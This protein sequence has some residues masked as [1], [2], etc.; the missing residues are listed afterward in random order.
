[1][2]EPQ[3][4]PAAEVTA[5]DFGYR[6]ELKRVLGVTDL[7]ILGLCMAVPISVVII[8]GFVIGAAQGAIAT[9]YLLAGIGMLLTGNSYARLSESF[10][11][12][13]GGY[14]F[15]SRG[16]SRLAGF[17]IGWAMAGMYLVLLPLL[18]IFGA[19]AL[20]ALWPA[21]PV[22]L[23]LAAFIALN[24]W[25]NYR[26]LEMTRNILR[27]ILG[28]GLAIYVWTVIA[29]L[30]AVMHGTG[31]AAF[32][33]APFSAAGQFDLLAVMAG[34]AIAVFNFGGPEM[35]TTLGEETKGGTRTLGR[36]V[37]LSFGLLGAF[38]L[39]LVWAAALAWPDYTT[40]GDAETAFYAI[41]E[42]VGGNS[43]KSAL[44]VAIVVTM[45]GS[46]ISAQACSARLLYAMGRDRM[47]P[48]WLARVHPKYQ[49]PYA[50]VLVTAVVSTLLCLAFPDQA[51]VMTSIVNFSLLLCWSFVNVT[52]IRFLL[53][54][55][56]S[57]R[58]FRDL[59]CPLLGLAVTGYAFVSLDD[60]ALA[61]GLAWLGLGVL[62]AFYLRYVRKVDWSF[63]ADAGL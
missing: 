46:C 42:R 26:G 49:S 59:A 5:A 25:A 52:A 35:L 12:A 11:L 16:L 2:T 50:G 44:V 47:L 37:L 17:L 22:Q 24:T 60:A 4:A 51:E 40:L 61:A 27:Y 15:V 53:L 48:R 58:W 9:V 62:F 34:V 41:A 13:G 28:A 39:L 38:F 32:T 7:V 8:Y 18:Y 33:A 57:G 19:H 14:A 31:G 1:M 54:R 3:T 21:V 23:W 63:A 56:Q 45:L 30:V 10:P 20:R 43:L 55:Q 29:C 36:G 6:Q